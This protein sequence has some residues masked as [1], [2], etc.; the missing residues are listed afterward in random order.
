MPFGKIRWPR[1]LRARLLAVFLTGMVLSAGL[2]ALAVWVLAGP[3]QQY[4]LKNG[5]EEYAEGVAHHVRFDRG[6]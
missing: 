3:F 4:M 6:G 1:S 5:I 2:V